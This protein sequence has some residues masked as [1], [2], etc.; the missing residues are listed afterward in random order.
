MLSRIAIAALIGTSIE[1]NTTSSSS[2]VRP[3]TSTMNTGS[4][5]ESR[6]RPDEE[7]RLGGSGLGLSI[8]AELA[9]A[10]GGDAELETEPGRGCT[11][12]VRIP[13]A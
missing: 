1:R 2:M 3:M 13:T 7:N 11:F 12:T 9:R 10:H 8:V 5:S 6:S 4:A